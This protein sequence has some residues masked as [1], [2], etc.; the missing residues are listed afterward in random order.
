MKNDDNQE[1]PARN[2]KFVAEWAVMSVLLFGMAPLMYGLAVE[3]AEKR[4]HQVEKTCP[5]HLTKRRI[6]SFKPFITKT[7][8][9]QPDERKP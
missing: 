3:N 5:P 6:I 4:K 1:P 2:R 9:L 8:C 7:T